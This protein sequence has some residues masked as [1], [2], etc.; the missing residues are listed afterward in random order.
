MRRLHR[1]ALWTA[2]R[3]L[4]IFWFCFRPA[5]RGVLVAVLHAGRVLMIR[6]SYRKGLTLPGGSPRPG[7]P[8][9]RTA[10]RELMEETG[11][12]IPANRLRYA[13]AIR[14]RSEFKRD[15]VHLFQ[16]SLPDPPEL[17]IDGREVVDAAFV[18]M[19]RLPDLDLHPVLRALLDAN[20]LQ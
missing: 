7:E 6:N 15:T 11:I 13:G 4:L 10:G 16:L 12:R 2:Y 1:I 8:L 9:A 14:N 3:V 5:A 18:E 17:R 20:L 19:N